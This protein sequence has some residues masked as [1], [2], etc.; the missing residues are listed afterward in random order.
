MR[1]KERKYN[2]DNKESYENI[3][4]TQRVKVSAFNSRRKEILGDDPW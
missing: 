4:L 2:E 1:E 3:H